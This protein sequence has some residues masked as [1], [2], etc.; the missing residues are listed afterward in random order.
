M[1]S[2]SPFNVSLWTPPPPAALAGGAP[3]T[4]RDRLA[5]GCCPVVGLFGSGCRLGSGIVPA[6]RRVVGRYRYQSLGL[7]LGKENGNGLGRSFLFPVAVVGLV[8]KEK[9]KGMEW[10]Y[11][12][13]DGY[14]EEAESVRW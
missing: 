4:P 12:L 1:T 10:V 8:D 5:K 11:L 6:S 9:W 13:V 7:G 14:L 2:C 3:P